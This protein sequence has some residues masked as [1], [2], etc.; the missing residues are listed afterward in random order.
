MANVPQRGAGGS[1]LRLVLKRAL[2]RLGLLDRARWTRDRVNALAWLRHDRRFLRRGDGDG[3]PVPPA[4]L[5]ILTTASPS[6]EW[7]IQSGRSGADSI[8]DLLAR[9]GVPIATIG[10][11]LDFGCGC[12][13]VLRH[14]ADSDLQV[15]GCDYNVDLVAWCRR[16]LPFA[17]FETNTIEPPL[18]YPD[19]SFDLVYALSVFTHLPPA[20]QQRWIGEMARILRPTGYL[21]VSTHGEGYLETLTTDEQDRI[22]GGQLVVHHDEE[23]GTNRCGVFFSEAYVRGDF[24][25]GFDV[26]DYAPR[27]ARGNPPQDLVLLQAQATPRLGSTPTTTPPPP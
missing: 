8:R 27:G 7:F 24:A 19:A 10:S 3:L 17:R 26:R 22:R 16:K 6:V 2:R 18:P 12:G 15:A 11:M 13:R 4:R 5:R 9:N 1:F 23:A 25:P 14:W 21:I 20:L